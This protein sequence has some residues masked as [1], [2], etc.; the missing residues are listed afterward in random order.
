[1]AERP[2]DDSFLARWSRRK[3]V[4][5]EADDGRAQERSAREE[6]PAERS[7][8]DPTAAPSEQEIVSRLPDIDSMDDSSDFT[9]FL[10]KGVPEALRRQALKKLWRVNPLFAHLDGLND[11]DE[12][13]TAVGLGVEGL[14]TAYKVGKGYLSDDE[15]ADP[16]GD[17]GVS[18]AESPAPSEVGALDDAAA[19][20]TGKDGPPANPETAPEAVSAGTATDEVSAALEVS[21]AAAEAPL[22]AKPARRSGARAV[23]RRWGRRDS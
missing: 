20:D 18:A 12:D 6:A 4:R 3:Q 10:Q 8:A 9:V 13:F 21:K 16:A 14:K 1:M 2:Y 11:Y 17:P 19:D 23:E 22:A 7:D 15:P 5:P